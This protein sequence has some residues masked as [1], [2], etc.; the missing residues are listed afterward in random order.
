MAER[1]VLTEKHLTHQ[2]EELEI[3]MPFPQDRCDLVH[4]FTASNNEI[5]FDYLNFVDVEEMDV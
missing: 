2:E 5:V 3:L 4:N 1:Q